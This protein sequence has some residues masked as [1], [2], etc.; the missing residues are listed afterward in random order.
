MLLV[1][2]TLEHEPIGEKSNQEEEQDGYQIIQ[3]MLHYVRVATGRADN[4]YE[5]V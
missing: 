3:V 5:D 1:T 2:I 4:S